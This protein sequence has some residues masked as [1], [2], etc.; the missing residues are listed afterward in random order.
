M[1]NIREAIEDSLDESY[2]SEGFNVTVKYGVEGYRVYLTLS[3][4]DNRFQYLSWCGYAGTD[5]LISF[6]EEHADIDTKISEYFF[7]FLASP[8]SYLYFDYST[9]YTAQYSNNQEESS[10]YAIEIALNDGNRI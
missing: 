10:V 1:Q 3:N 2:T 4:E 5:F 6:K 9:A 7:D 8:Y